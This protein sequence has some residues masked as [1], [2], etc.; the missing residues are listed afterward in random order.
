LP[1][2]FPFASCSKAR[3]ASASRNVEFEHRFDAETL[4]RCEKRE[5]ARDGVASNLNG[6]G[7]EDLMLSTS[8]GVSV[9]SERGRS[10]RRA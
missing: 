5:E 10:L 4:E 2:T 8:S 7:L 6:D 3:R 9:L 1:N